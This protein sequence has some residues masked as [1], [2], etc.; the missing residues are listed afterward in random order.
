MCVGGFIYLKYII[1]LDNVNEDLDYEKKQWSIHSN[2][3]E[4]FFR[5]RNKNC[6]QEK[7]IMFLTSIIQ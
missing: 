5:S 6:I 7:D 2:K 3:R 1:V 4:L